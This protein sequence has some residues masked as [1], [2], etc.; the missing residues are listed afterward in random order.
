MKKILLGLAAV[1]VV[2]VALG[3][4]FQE[5]LK[6]VAYDALT[7]DMFV[8]TDN[9]SFEPGVTGTYEGDRFPSVHVAYQGGE[10]TS[11]SE[12]TGDRGLVVMFSRSVVW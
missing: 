9:D 8:E 4:V 1:I 2:L 7:S 3:F 12:F 11:L 6:D 5:P 10:L